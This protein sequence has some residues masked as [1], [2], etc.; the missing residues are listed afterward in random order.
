MLIRKF[1]AEALGSVAGASD[2][3]FRIDHRAGLLL[4]VV[5][6]SDKFQSGPY[7]ADGN[8]FHIDESCTEPQLAHTFIVEIGH[9]PRTFLGPTPPHRP[10]GCQIPDRRGEFSEKR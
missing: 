10:G 2:G 6:P 7:F 3:G 9:N 4:S 1:A 8:H 5:P